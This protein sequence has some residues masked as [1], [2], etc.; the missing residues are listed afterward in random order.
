M[1]NRNR[2]IDV[3]P[4]TAPGRWSSRDKADSRLS[5]SGRP[6]SRSPTARRERQCLARP[7]SAKR[8]NKRRA[9]GSN[10]SPVPKRCRT[11]I[12]CGPPRSTRALELLSDSSE[13]VLS[14]LHRPIDRSAQLLDAVALAETIAQ[15]WADTVALRQAVRSREAELA[16]DVP[17]VARREEAGR[18]AAALRGHSQSRRRGGSLSGGRSLSARR[19][20][21]H[22]E[23]AR[24]LGPARA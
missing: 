22:I 5:A 6:G 2:R 18:T 24:R 20:H 7:N 14:P 1:E 21:H 16:A 10:T 3:G 8:L 17:V 13:P 11:R 19:R 15:L 23:T 4:M 12:W 9:G